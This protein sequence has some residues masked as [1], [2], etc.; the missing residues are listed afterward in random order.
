MVRFAGIP[1]E[2][3]RSVASHY[4][5]RDV[6]ILA[7]SWKLQIAYHL[8]WTNQSTPLPEVLACQA[9]GEWHNY[10]SLHSPH[11]W[12]RTCASCG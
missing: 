4:S 9:L 11:S 7:T 12:H 3:V 1:K 2:I 8:A 5:H 6:E 10:I